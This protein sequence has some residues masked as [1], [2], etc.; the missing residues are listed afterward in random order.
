MMVNPIY[1][2]ITPLYD[3]RMT[4]IARLVC[5]TVRALLDS[6]P[7]RLVSPLLPGNSQECGLRE[8]H[9]R[10]EDQ[11]HRRHDD[12][13]LWR[14]HLWEQPS[15]PFDASLASQC[16]VFYGFMIYP[17]RR[18]RKEVGYIHDFTP[19]LVPQTHRADTVTSYATLF[20]DELRPYDKAV[21]N[22]QA[23]AD[24]ATWVCGL[25]AGD[26]VVS[27]P[28]PSLCVDAH[29]CRASVDRV[30]GRLLVVSTVEPRKNV[31]FLLEWF[32]T[33]G[34]LPAN[35]ELCW[36]GPQGWLESGARLDY[37]NP[38]GRR[39]RF[40][41]YVSDTVLCELYRS[42]DCTIYPSLYE[43]FGF[44][45]LDSLLHGTPVMC[46]YH[47][48]LKE[49]DGPGV[50]YFD[51]CDRETVDQA[52]LE[53]CN[54]DTAHFDRPDLQARCTWQGVAQTV[55]ELCSAE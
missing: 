9:S 52:Y 15:C 38:Y 7:V 2:D 23:T 37:P 8:I 51:P 14:A 5:R 16:S 45:V 18:F 11:W 20:G 43:G 49:F 25:S 48:A 29:A 3:R 39:V 26:I 22:S 17:T 42:A 53:M 44:P 19:L 4:G 6:V 28:G 46:G 12:L 13:D 10:P 32:Y 40:L 1:V 21:A 31:R 27:Y 35:A 33:S 55:I 24:D 50:F 41:G 30:P 47:S 54:R 36:A 34:V